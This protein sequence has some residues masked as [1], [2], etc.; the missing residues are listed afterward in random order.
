MHRFARLVAIV[1]LPLAGCGDASPPAPATFL[2]LG[3]SYTIG[4]SVDAIDR[5]P[6]QLAAAL[7]R[8]GIDLG[9]PRIIATT[10]WTTTDLL[11]AMD[12]ERFEKSYGS[13]R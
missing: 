11:L 1:L 12:R 4:Q 9:E 13:S 5:W 10:G 6:T 8:Q 3:D 2:A 7:Q